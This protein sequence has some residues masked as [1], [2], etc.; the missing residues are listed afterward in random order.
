[1]KTLPII[2]LQNGR[3]IGSGQ[4]CFLVAEIGNNHQGNEDT[5]REMIDKAA[6]SGADAVKFQKRDTCALLTREGREKPYPGP[7][8]FGPTYGEHRD[9]LELPLEAMGRLKDHAQTLGLTFFASPWDLPSLD[10]LARLDLE[11]IKIA[12]ADLT[13]LP[14]IRRASE[15]HI[16]LILSTGMSTFNE[17]AQT[18]TEIRRHHSQLVL[19]HCNS[20]YPCPPEEVALLVMRKLEQQFGLPVGYSGHETGIAPSI[21]AVALGA[22]VVERHFTLDRNLPGT[23]HA[24]SL[25]PEGFT[26][27][28][29]MIRETEAALA[30][31]EKCVTPVEA[32]CAIKLRKSIVAA[33]DLP[34]GILLQPGDLTVKSPGDGL[35]PLHWDCVVG[36]VTAR[37]LLEDQRLTWDDL[38]TVAASKVAAGESA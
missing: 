22:C 27:M 37:P 38:A 30:V 3:T 18:V 4:P 31:P 35:S 17:I 29:T 14:L 34:R 21:A 26:R 6:Q 13:T 1:M 9:A 12:S 33:R 25:D 2:K 36:S 15:L 23:D 16:P 11:L 32:A 8:S 28:V 20:S 10:G 7:N 5:A 19:L 24:A